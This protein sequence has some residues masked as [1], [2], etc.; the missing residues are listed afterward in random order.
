MPNTLPL[1]NPV[2]TLPLL[3]LK[4]PILGL[5]S[6]S[7]PSGWPEIPTPISTQFP[8]SWRWAT[9]SSWSIL[10]SPLPSPNGGGK[11]H[12]ARHKSCTQGAAPSGSPANSAL[13]IT[14]LLTASRVPSLLASFL[15]SVKGPY[16]LKT[17]PMP[18]NH[19]PLGSCSPFFFTTND[20]GFFP[21]PVLT[22]VSHNAD[23]FTDL[24]TLEV[25]LCLFTQTSCS[26]ALKHP[27]STLSLSACKLLLILRISRYVHGPILSTFWIYDLLLAFHSRRSL[28]PLKELSGDTVPDCLHVCPS[29]DREL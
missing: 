23:Q 13:P 6:V 5:W 28:P 21:P 17:S 16:L 12:F 3:K 18:I 29:L 26:L 9:H 19:T 22:S 10:I 25:L 24:Q 7:T 20:S 27:N 1:W 11:Q 15:Q 8:L 2:A 14:P 4:H